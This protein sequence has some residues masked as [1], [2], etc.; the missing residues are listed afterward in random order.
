MVNALSAMGGSTSR[1]RLAPP[2]LACQR[3]GSSL[4]AI[5]SSACVLHIVV[6]HFLLLGRSHP[7]VF[8]QRDQVEA[9]FS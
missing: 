3:P 9:T 5:A 7:Q 4:A 8:V 1:A 6:E 2:F